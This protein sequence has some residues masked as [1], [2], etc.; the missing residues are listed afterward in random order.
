MVS[1]KSTMKKCK[2]EQRILKYLAIKKALAKWQALFE[3]AELTAP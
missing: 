3:Q 2:Y 1:S